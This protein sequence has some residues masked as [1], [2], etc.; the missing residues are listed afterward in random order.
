[1]NK[2]PATELDLS[3]PR[4]GDKTYVARFRHFLETTSPLNVFTSSRKLAEA[5]A[6]VSAHKYVSEV[7]GTCGYTCSTSSYSFFLFES[8]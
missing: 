7:V 1:M 5:A 2:A 6:L 8:P 4:Y 3:K